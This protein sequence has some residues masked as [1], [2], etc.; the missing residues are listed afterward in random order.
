MRTRV[1]LL[2]LLIVA[3]AQLDVY[4]QPVVR[5]SG[6]IT[7]AHTH[8]VLPRASVA[9]LGTRSGTIANSDGK[10]SLALTAGSTV[11]LRISSLSYRPDTI[12]ISIAADTRRDIELTP[13]PAELE[14]V[15]VT[16]DASREQAR[17][18][19]REVIRRKKLWRDCLH[20]YQCTAYSRWNMRTISG[21]D[22]T[23]RSV[24]ESNADGYWRSDK[25]LYERVTAR[26]QTANFPAEANQFSLGEIMN[27]YDNRIDFDEFSLTTPVADDA[28]SSYDYDLVGTGTVGN[29]PV[30][31]IRLYPGVASEAFDGVVWIDQID[32]SI[33]YLD[34]TPSAAVKL[35]PM[36]DIR[37]QQTFDL[38][39]DTFWMPVNLRSQVTFKLDLPFVP[40]FKLELIT[41]IKDYSINTS[42]P[43]SM[44]IG[45]RHRAAPQADSTSKTVFEESRPI[46][47]ATDEAK[48]YHTIDSSVAA[49]KSDSSG[50]GFSLLDVLSFLD[51]PRYDQIEGFRFGIAQS[52]KPLD[53]W[54]LTLSG[55]LAYGLRDKQWKYDVGL[56][57]GLIWK[58]QKRSVFTGSLSGEF[59]G[60]Y[61]DVQDV[62]LWLSAHYFDDL[63][64]RGDAY[65]SV[66]TSITSLI[67]KR[68][69]QQFY[70]HKGF[71]VGL[72]GSPVS[73]LQPSLTYRNENIWDA[74]SLRLV[75]DSIPSQ[76]HTN[77][78]LALSLG[79]DIPVHGMSIE[80]GATLTTAS[81]GLGSDY[82]F[83]TAQVD[84]SASKRLGGWGV[85]QIT[86][87]YQTTLAGGLPR[88]NLLYF[89][90]RDEFFSKF[91]HI[92]G[93][94]PFEFMGD[95]IWSVDI[96]HNFYDL[97]TRLLGLNFLDPLN[98][99]WRVH[100]AIAATSITHS[101]T[102]P[103]ATTGER[104]YTEIGFGVGNIYHII[105]LDATWRLDHKTGSDFYP[106]VN[107][108]FVF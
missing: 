108:Q 26:R 10:Y 92:R 6:T 16:S 97:P 19:M 4:A 95:R 103:A 66:E 68:D 96:D 12:T 36:K 57:Q 51:I 40:Q 102:A 87:L 90:T 30:W 105:N 32:Y 27:F 67:Y 63:A 22:T 61:K 84:L 3:A 41:L 65:S 39:R 80:L 106:S 94:K 35:G 64:A 21:D 59:S 44:F 28:F 5:L 37:L 20:S 85:M 52:V 70:R 7:D 101:A 33:A 73:G 18:I 71:S 99:Q 86:G 23:V 29:S 81:H 82:A 78:T 45:P 25:G 55:A 48:A 79:Y 38:F 77:A 53:S 93:M 72:D 15:V 76:K 34:L 42:I 62:W 69:Y 83:T 75:N 2:L 13:Y 1:L 54:P 88:W 74:D 49:H 43:D 9:I 100:A 47:L 46:P 14:T 58:T 31:K 107:L 60:E 91:D 11:R 89:E 17:K 104:P 56:R 8:E 24:V 50:G 98:L